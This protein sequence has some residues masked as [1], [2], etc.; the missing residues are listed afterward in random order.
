M[1][2]VS[3]QVLWIHTFLFSLLSCPVLQPPPIHWPCGG[4]GRTD[5]QNRALY[6]FRVESSKLLLVQFMSS[7]NGR[8]LSLSLARSL[9]LRMILYECVFVC[10]FVGCIMFGIVSLYYS[11]STRSRI[12]VSLFYSFQAYLKLKWTYTLLVYGS[13]FLYLFT[14]AVLLSVCRLF[15]FVMFGF[16]VV[17]IQLFK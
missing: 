2:S 14:L 16:F 6:V 10:V 15:V 7:F 5:A 4:W 17:V 9:M 12:C 11:S 3:R 13:N 8:F 1:S